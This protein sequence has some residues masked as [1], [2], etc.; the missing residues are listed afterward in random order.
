LLL[1]NVVEI[2]VFG[3]VPV[4]NEFGDTFA[5]V[6]LTQNTNDHQRHGEIIIK[7]ILNN[8]IFYV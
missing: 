8:K 1:E 4:C 7:T 2:G 3:Y 5:T 6:R